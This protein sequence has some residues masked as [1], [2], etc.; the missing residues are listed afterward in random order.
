MVMDQFSG[1][2]GPVRAFCAASAAGDIETALALVADDAVY[3]LHLSEGML[4]FVGESRGKAAIRD[5]L[6]QMRQ[7]FDYLLWR[8]FRM[9]SE[10]ETVRGQIE[11]LYRHRASGEQIAGRCRL[12]WTVRD[13][14]LVACQEY[15]DRAMFETFLRLVGAA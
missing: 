5:T 13:G 9:S 8:P 3:T 15:Q 6:G 7:H 2:E 10:G 4:P 12:V 1:T 11:F 14:K